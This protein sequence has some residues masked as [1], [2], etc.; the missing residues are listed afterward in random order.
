[1][2]IEQSDVYVLLKPQ[3]SW[4]RGISKRDIA[5]QIDHAIDESTP[6]I[7]TAIS[8]PIQM[9][10][11]EL[12]AGSRSDVSIQVYGPDLQRLQALCDRIAEV[13]QR[14]PG[15]VDVRATQSS[16][17]RY[18]RII[19]DRARLARYGLTVDDVNLLTEMMSVGHRTGVIFE[20]DRR[21]D[22]VAKLSKLDGS[23]EQ[24]E[25]RRL[26]VEL[27]CAAVTWSRSSRRPA[28]QWT[29]R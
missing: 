19:P 6:E 12:I 21:F 2:G 10:T 4:R 25:A 22:L 9:R 16:G 13:V 14:V 20:G 29:R 24:V 15:A 23:L 8:Q 11:N 28:A 18:M 3:T 1:M 17:L 7:A 26:S 27:N 5:E